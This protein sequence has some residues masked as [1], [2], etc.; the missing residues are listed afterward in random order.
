MRYSMTGATGFLGGVLARQLVEAGH[1]VTALVRDPSRADGLRDLGVELV[2]G[3]LDDT[4]ALDELLLGANGFF[5]VAGWY[6]HGMREHETL[7]RVNIDGTRNALEAARRAGVARTVY[8]STIALNS[9]THGRTVAEDYRFTGTHV[10]EYDRTKAVAHE[11]AEEYAAAGL[12]LVI[13]QPSVIYGPGDVGST[14]GQITRQLVKGR[15]VLGPRSGG[16]CFAHVED[17]ARGHVLAMEQG[18][19]GESYIL[20]GPRAEF[21]DLM[22]RVRRLAG[23]GRVV[24]LPVPVVRAVATM[25]APVERVVPVPQ[26]LTAEAARSGLATYYGDAGKAEREL[27]WKSRPLEEGLAETVASIRSGS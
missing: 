4:A 19:L 25:T 13:V 21:G 2:E 22:G 1:Q 26:A 8:T 10:S 23:R 24:L 3:D 15:T 20:A 6:K 17:V 12:P 18:R 7:R 14:M 16:A 5:H 9:D 27:G 11:I